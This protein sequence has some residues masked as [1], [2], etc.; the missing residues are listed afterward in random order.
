LLIDSWPERIVI[1]LVA[2]ALWATYAALVR[3][4]RSPGP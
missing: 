2:A 3:R 1:L 4:W